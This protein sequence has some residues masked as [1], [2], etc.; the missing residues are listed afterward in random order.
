MIDETP[1]CPEVE[2]IN[3]D[4]P[5]KLGG[6]RKYRLPCRSRNILPHIISLYFA[7]LC[8]NSRQCPNNIDQ[9]VFKMETDGV[10]FDVGNEVVKCRGKFNTSGLFRFAGVD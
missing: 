7:R 1:P 3:R 2:S 10:L 8:V 9:L 5:L 4:S 6:N